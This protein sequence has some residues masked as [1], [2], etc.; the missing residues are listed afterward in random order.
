MKW[1]FHATVW[2][3]IIQDGI[4][5]TRAGGTAPEEGAFTV[6]TR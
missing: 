6:M 4:Q 3:P 2:L 1:G 5:E